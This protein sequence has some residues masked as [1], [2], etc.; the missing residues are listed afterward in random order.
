LFDNEGNI[1]GVV[2]AT[3][4]AGKLYQSASA[5]PQNVNWVI[6]SSYLLNLYSMLPG[7][8]P[9]AR[10]TAFSPDKAAGCVA[11]ITAW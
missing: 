1:L 7:Q 3:L 9:A 4:D 11:I 5:I 6:K 10:T 8:S 2:V